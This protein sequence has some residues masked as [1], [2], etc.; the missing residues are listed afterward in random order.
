MA[1][2]PVNTAHITRARAADLTAQGVER[3]RCTC[4]S[5]RRRHHF[6]ALVRHPRAVFRALC[7]CS[8]RMLRSDTHRRPPGQPLVS[9]SQLRPCGVVA[10]RAPRGRLLSAGTIATS[11]R[12]GTTR[13]PFGNGTFDFVM[14]SRD[15][16]LAP[17]AVL[18]TREY[19]R[20]LAP[21]GTS[22]CSTHRPRLSGRLI[23]RLPG[24]HCFPPVAFQTRAS[25]GALSVAPRQEVDRHALAQRF[26]RECLPSHGAGLIDV[27]EPSGYAELL[28]RRAS[29]ARRAALSHL[30]IACAA[31]RRR[32]DP[33]AGAALLHLV[34]RSDGE[35]YRRDRMRS[36]LPS[37]NSA[38]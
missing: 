10:I 27:T 38:R 14:P 12:R 6:L 8:S 2:A 11:H 31:L 20:V 24:I 32:T 17:R 9:E 7:S 29:R 34:C 13:L 1:S 33:V 16:H 15:R 30:R 37:A 5:R 22:R 21:G 26:L 28:K 4:R 25:C 35:R 19:Y 3:R 36:T 18:A 23:L